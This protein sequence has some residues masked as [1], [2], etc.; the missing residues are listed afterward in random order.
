MFPVVQL[1][2]GLPQTKQNLHFSICSSCFASILPNRLKS[3]VSPTEGITSGGYLMH[4]TICKI[5]VHILDRVL[6]S[7]QP[8]DYWISLALRG[9]SIQLLLIISFFL[10][11][12]LFLKRLALC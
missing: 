9:F 2:F 7:L 1:H 4:S 5:D 11:L 12:C 3:E 8:C 10:A 6:V